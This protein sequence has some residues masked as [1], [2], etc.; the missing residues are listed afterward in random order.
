MTFLLL[1]LL[2]V[3]CGSDR[4][5]VDAG[6]V[7]PEQ[8]IDSETASAESAIPAAD[9]KVVWEWLDANIKGQVDLAASREGQSLSGPNVGEELQFSL[10][11]NLLFGEQLTLLYEIRD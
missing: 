6:A 10:A 3:G 11:Q 9:E 8:V 7:D 1:L 2:C 4:S 5:K